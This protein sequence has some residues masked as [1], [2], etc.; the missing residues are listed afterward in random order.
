MDIMQPLTVIQDHY[1]VLGLSA[2]A[3][4]DDIY[5]AYHRII[6][7]QFPNAYNPDSYDDY[8]QFVHVEEAYKVLSNQT[9][10][11][12]YDFYY[13]KFILNEP[14]LKEENNDASCSTDGKCKTCG[15]NPDNATPGT[16]FLTWIVLIAL[17]LVWVLK[18]FF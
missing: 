6:A 18:D 14:Y 15:P 2:N 9:A 13:R 1:S 8:D 5:N 3:S 7:E 4:K 10:R 17:L 12:H 16:R 11:E